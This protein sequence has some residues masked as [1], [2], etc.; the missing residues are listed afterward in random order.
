MAVRRRRPL[1]RPPYPRRNRYTPRCVFD[2]RSGASAGA[3]TGSAVWNHTI[4]SLQSVL[5]F[6]EICLRCLYLHHQLDRHHL[7]QQPVKLVKQPG[8]I[9]T[10]PSRAARR[11]PPATRTWS[12]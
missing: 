1:I 7:G 12:Q 11:A 6:R 8:R 2:A 4:F 3:G 5:Q 9:D 10:S